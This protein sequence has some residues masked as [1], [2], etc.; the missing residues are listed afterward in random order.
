MGGLGSGSM[1]LFRNML[2]WERP[3]FMGV[4]G[5]MS[6]EGLGFTSESWDD[7]RRR[8]S[9]KPGKGHSQSTRSHENSVSIALYIPKMC[10]CVDIVKY[11]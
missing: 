4:A 2:S 8:F 3:R 10:T 9:P 1:S 7:A 6:R 5:D 11:T